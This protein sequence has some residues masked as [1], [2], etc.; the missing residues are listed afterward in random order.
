MEPS[1]AY[2]KDAFIFIIDEMFGEKF[3]RSE[4]NIQKGTIF[5][6]VHPALKSEIHIKKAKVIDLVN[7]KIEKNII[8]NII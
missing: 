2:I 3:E 8:K 4:I 1:D 6:K 5:L 7:Q